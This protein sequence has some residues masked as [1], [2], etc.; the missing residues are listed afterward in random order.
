[1]LLASG[2][3]GS[4]LQTAELLLLKD[5]ASILLAWLSEP[6]APPAVTQVFGLAI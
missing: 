1:M 6:L 2:S 3:L 5:G 4:S